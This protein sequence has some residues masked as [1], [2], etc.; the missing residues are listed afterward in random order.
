MDYRS[1]APE[2]IRDFLNYHEV[3]RGHSQKTV[4]EYYLDLRTFLRF[5]LRRRGM[6]DAKTPFDETDISGVDLDFLAAVDRS[7]IYDYMSFLSRD[8]ESGHGPRDKRSGLSASS[9]ARKLATLRSLFKYLTVKTGM[10]EKN[11][12]DG[13]DSPRTKRS[14]PKYLSLEE[15]I[16]L[17]SSVGGRNAV[18]DRCI[19]T[20]FLNCGLRISEL[21]GL[22]MSDFSEDHLRVFGK[23][24]K[25]RVVYL[26][27]AALASVEEYAALRRDIDAESPALFLSEQKNRIS[28]STV[29]R[30]VKNHL[31][32][33]GL[34]MEGY[35]SHKLRHTAA[36]LMLKNGVDLR[37]LQELLGHEHLN[38]TEIYT[39]VENSDLRTAARA[40][41]LSSFDPDADKDLDK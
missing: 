25:E 10:L 28:R 11:P 5:L 4:D 37:T 6:V 21:A 41:P 2:I 12:L 19:L 15:S 13:F 8:R 20:V 33:A 27:G 38:T 31:G 35:S 14:L 36:T 17:L 22:N 1:E 23:G 16:R 34:A 7:E 9:R 40:N 18:R 24:G 32:E 30:L 29:H 39:H 3:I 26:D